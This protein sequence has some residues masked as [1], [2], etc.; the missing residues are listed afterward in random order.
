MKSFLLLMVF[1]LLAGISNH[2]YGSEISEK[3]DN[4]PGQFRETV[5]MIEEGNFVFNARRVHPGAGRSI[6]LSTRYAVM[7]I[8]GN[9][10]KAR[11]PFF[12][13]AYQ[14]RYSGR[15]GIEFSGPMENV[16]ISEDP[17]RKRINYSF[18]VR[19]FDHYRVNMVIHANG[20]TTVYINS[21]Y[22]SNISYQ[23]RISASG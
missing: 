9:D 23:G 2:S 5:E 13:R 1:A 18:D 20:N 8:S 17:D 6:D 7:E 4:S 19:D 16:T 14:L 21:N 12:G 3:A 15:G 11:L 10:A 22:R